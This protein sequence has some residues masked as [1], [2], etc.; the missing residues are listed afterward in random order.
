ML[1]LKHLCRDLYYTC[2]QDEN[3]IKMLESNLS[4]VGEELHIDVFGHNVHS[5]GS[6]AQWACAEV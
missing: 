2:E 4:I 1:L 3:F 6:L 5:I